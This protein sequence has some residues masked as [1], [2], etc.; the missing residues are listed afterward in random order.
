M[1]MKIENLEEQK[2]QLLA[3]D[4][5]NLVYRYVDREPV[6]E[7]V[8]ITIVKQNIK[9]L[10]MEAKQLKTKDAKMRRQIV[11]KNDRWHRF[12][13]T[14]P[15]IFDRVIHPD[16]QQEQI[17]ALEKMIEFFEQEQNGQMQNAKQHFENYLINTHGVPEAEYKR[18]NPQHEIRN[19]PIK[20]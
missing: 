6:K 17:G 20:K 4:P 11:C 8:P 13:E 3:D 18:A 1:E 14:H 15:D 10:W 7:V 2:L 16:T 9:D 12:S 19:V 5:T